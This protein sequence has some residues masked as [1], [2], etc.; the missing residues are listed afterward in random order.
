MDG[1]ANIEHAWNHDY[2]RLNDQG[3]N[4]IKLDGGK[5]WIM[6]GKWI[7]IMDEAW[8]KNR[9]QWMNMAGNWCR[10]D[11]EWMKNGWKNAWKWIKKEKW[12]EDVQKNHVR[13]T[14]GLPSTK[15]STW[16]PNLE[17]RVLL[18]FWANCFWKSAVRQLCTKTHSMFRVPDLFWLTGAVFRNISVTHS[19]FFQT[20]K[21]IKNWGF[22]PRASIRQLFGY[23]RRFPNGHSMFRSA[24]IELFSLCQFQVPSTVGDEQSLR[25]AT[26]RTDHRCARSK[27]QAR[28]GTNS[29]FVKPPHERI[30][31]LEG[32][33]NPGM[34]SWLKGAACLRTG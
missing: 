30:I 3:L 16:E 17:W 2:I 12:I 9:W 11:E 7:E 31:V 33:R 5:Q 14:F 20:R 23:P 19:K 10:M 13:R 25:Q 21:K 27:F 29:L 6:D 18:L 28:L 26:T 34:E 15:N 32:E 1:N 8:M 24:N 22:W 4:R